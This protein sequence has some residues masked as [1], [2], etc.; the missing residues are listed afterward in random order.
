MKYI[1]RF[2]FPTSILVLLVVIGVNLYAL[3]RRQAL[4]GNQDQKSLHAHAN[5][6]PEEQASKDH[7]HGNPEKA[8]PKTEEKKDHADHS[9]MDHKGMG[10]GMMDHK[11][12]MGKGGMGMMQ[13]N[14][15]D[16]MD[17]RFLLF[18]HEKIKRSVKRLPNGVETVT[19]S[20]DDAV[21]S[22]IQV[23]VK[24]MYDR[25]QKKQTIRPM[26]PLFVGLFENADKID[27]VMTN[28]PDGIIVKE[29]SKDAYTVKLIHAHADAVDRFVKEGMSA[30]MKFTPAPERESM[31]VEVRWSGELKNMMMKG[32][33]SGTIDLAA[34]AK[35]PHMYAVGALEGLQGEVTL[36]DGAATLVSVRDGKQTISQTPQ[37]KASVLVYAQVK[38]WKKISLPKSIESL[39]DL[40]TFVV[41]A[42]RKEGII[43]DRPFPFVV[44]GIVAEAKYHVLRHPGEVKDPRELHDKAQVP[45]TL[46]AK[47][48]ELVGFYSDKHLGIFTCQSNLHVHLRTADGSESGHLDEVRLGEG[49]V[50]CLPAH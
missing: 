24:A 2:W 27:L 23:H 7:G 30:M 4:D 35:V 21:A 3:N 47:N 20:A 22:K 46:R 32:D 50:L 19:S 48:L 34:I 10:K 39:A 8:V 25:L 37:G 40:E 17:I 29:T 45:F 43:V 15:A 33:V 28:L 44:K 13:G 6:K 9:M 18:N 38:Q 11:G 1:R 26:D 14:M 16:M 12:M 49:M 41:E 42:A 36:I 31:P 5:P